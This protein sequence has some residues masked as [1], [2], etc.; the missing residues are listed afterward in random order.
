LPLRS[1]SAGLYRRRRL[2][3]LHKSSIVA[4]GCSIRRIVLLASVVR[5]TEW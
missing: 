4:A 2:R 1:G 5:N 3:R